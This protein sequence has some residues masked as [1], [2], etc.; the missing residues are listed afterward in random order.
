[1]YQLFHDNKPFE[2][3]NVLVIFQ[4]SMSSFVHG[5]NLD[6]SYRKHPWWKE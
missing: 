6:L 2:N 5:V 1:M 3:E 4:T